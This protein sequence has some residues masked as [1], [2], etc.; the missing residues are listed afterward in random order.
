MSLVY[1]NSM[2]DSCME[3]VVTDRLATFLSSHDEFSTT[4]RSNW[5]NVLANV[6]RE[7]TL[8]MY[9]SLSD[10]Y[11]EGEWRFDIFPREEHLGVEILQ[12]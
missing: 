4:L 10:H 3:H 8:S 11:A 6:Q 7:K 9:V 12:D 2:I 1:E 5:D